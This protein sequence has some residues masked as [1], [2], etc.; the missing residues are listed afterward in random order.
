MTTYPSNGSASAGK[1]LFNTPK[2]PRHRN[3]ACNSP[4]LL[5]NIETRTLIF[6]GFQAT[7]RD[8]LRGIACEIWGGLSGTR[9]ID[10]IDGID[11]IYGRM[12]TQSLPGHPWPTATAVPKTQTTSAQTTK[13]EPLWPKWSA[14]WADCQ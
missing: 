4:A 10:G 11:C 14:L 1:L 2:I 6:R 12:Q 3:L 5:S 8:T 13:I 7:S 9:G